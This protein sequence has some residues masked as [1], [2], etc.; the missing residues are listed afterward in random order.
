M[1]RRFEV[2]DLASSGFDTFLIEGYPYPG[3]NHTLDKATRCAEY[4]W[5]EVAWDNP[6]C[7]Y[8]TGSTTAPD[9]A[10]GNS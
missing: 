9:R 7:R 4:P 5:K 1:S 10:C 8:L 6:H 2:E 3:I